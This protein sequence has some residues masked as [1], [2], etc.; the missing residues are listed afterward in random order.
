MNSQ[1]VLLTGVTGFLGS[2]T[3]IRLLEKGY[4]VI[5][6]LRDM[7]RAA[8][9]GEVIA[10]H[11]AYAHRLTFAQADLQDKEKWFDLTKGVDFVQ[12]VASPF[13]REVPKHEDDIIIP[14][15]EGVLNIMKAAAA[16]K[17][18]RFVLTS[19]SSAV[20][21]G[22]TPQQQAKVM[23]ESDWTNVD[24]ARDLTPY[25]KSKAVAEKAA[26]DFIKDD[27][28][29]MELVTV[30]P[31]A[32]LGPVLEQDFG[33]SANI[34]I[35]ILDGSVPAL[36]KVGFEI[37]DVRSAADAL[38]RAMEIP[39]A[40]QNRYLASAGFLMMKDIAQILR[41]AYPGRKLPSRE[42]PNFLVRLLAKFDATLGPILLDLGIKR[43]VDA[44][45]ARRDLQWQPVSTQEAV[46]SCAKSIF[47][48]GIVK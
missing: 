25:F 30:L 16:N 42:L 2:H 20:G 32:I 4:E 15:R 27:R 5:G 14:A 1:R 28:S 7:D 36:P 45:K 46:L 9:I 43:Q 31:G 22:K 8:A 26:W 17:V 10:R 29:G 44:S 12:H 34:V 13:P 3:T 37:V 40:A 48:T 39:E 19:S 35:K 47:E 24:Y 41:K 33:T 23:N 21:Y 18:K 6:T 38:I 11:T